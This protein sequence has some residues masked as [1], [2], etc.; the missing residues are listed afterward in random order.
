MLDKTGLLDIHVPD[1]CSPNLVAWAWTMRVSTI[2][3]VNDID[4][5]ICIDVDID[6]DD[7]DNNV[8]NHVDNDKKQDHRR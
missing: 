6:L 4:I 8:T 3:T 2:I 7:G 5:D 1:I